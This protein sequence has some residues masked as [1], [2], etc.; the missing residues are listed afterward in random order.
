MRLTE[1]ISSV[2]ELPS[3]EQVKFRYSHINPNEEKMRKLIVDERKKPSS[4]QE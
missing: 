2:K 3:S 4:T 1:F